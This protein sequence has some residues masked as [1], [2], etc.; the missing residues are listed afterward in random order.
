MYGGKRHGSSAANPKLPSRA[1]RTGGVPLRAGRRSMLS[2]AGGPC[3]R[4]SWPRLRAP[5]TPVTCPAL[6]RLAII[7]AAIPLRQCTCQV[8]PC[9]QCR[10]SNDMTHVTSEGSA[11]LVERVCIKFGVYKYVPS[12]SLNWDISNLTQA[13]S[14]RSVIDSIAI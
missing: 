12:S 14:V 4:R 1:D 7:P 3:K 13:Y 9:S 5:G 11:L 2:T 8:R 6:N 10:S